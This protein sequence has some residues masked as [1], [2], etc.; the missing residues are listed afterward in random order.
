MLGRNVHSLQLLDGRDGRF[1]LR[2]QLDALRRP[3][4]RLSGG[5]TKIFHDRLK[6][7]KL[8]MA[9][10]ILADELIDRALGADQPLLE[11]IEPDQLIAKIRF[12]RET[13]I[14]TDALQSMVMQHILGGRL[15]CGP[16]R[17]CA[18]RR[19]HRRANC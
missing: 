5:C 15:A 12:F 17:S 13:P 8:G 14:A 19:H 16:G 4:L 2:I 9:S 18:D 3:R 7:H 1:H 11:A 6:L 10:F